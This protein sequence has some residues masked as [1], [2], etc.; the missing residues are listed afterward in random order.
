MS[1]GGTLRRNRKRRSELR[2]NSTITY[3]SNETSSEFLN[4]QSSTSSRFNEPIAGPSHL[5]N[6]GV[7]SVNDERNSEDSSEN[8][9]ALVENMRSSDVLTAPELQLDCFSDS[10]TESSTND[11]LPVVS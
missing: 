8:V 5:I 6:P 3:S 1:R 7:S 11:V 2:N 10:S 9:Q 4:K